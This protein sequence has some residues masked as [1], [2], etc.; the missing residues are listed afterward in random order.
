MPQPSV[1]QISAPVRREATMKRNATDG[2][3]STFQVWYGLT[4]P[5]G[6]TLNLASDQDWTGTTT[7]AIAIECPPSMSIKNTQIFV[8]WGMSI[9]NNLVSTDAIFG[10]NL[11]YTNMGGTT[12]AT[13][14]SQLKLQVRNAGTTDL[15]CDQVTAYGVNR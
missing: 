3:L 1:S 12:V 6:Q 7:V 2:S 9:A 15:A 13:Y 10:S 5:A 8:W 14:G 4:I 11:T